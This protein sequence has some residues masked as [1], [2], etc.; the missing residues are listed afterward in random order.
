MPT[1]GSD[2]RH[3]QPGWP[4]D[5]PSASAPSAARHTNT[6]ASRP[7]PQ[8]IAL[9]RWKLG[10]EASR[11]ERRPV[12]RGAVAVLEEPATLPQTEPETRTQP[13]SV[14]AGRTILVVEDDPRVAGVIQESLALDGDAGW[15]VQTASGGLRAL[16]LAGSTPPDVVL[17]DVRLPDL[18]G[19]E[20][21]RRLRAGPQTRAARILFL[22][23]GTSLDLYRQGIEDGVL[24][25]KPFDVRDLVGIVRALLAD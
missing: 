21:Y 18:D 10:A 16:D 15:V 25:R 23:A 7:R 9:P 20:V 3:L 19:A 14:E 17:L 13:R 6:R 24:L 1:S 12:A 2:S 8:L 22:T 5:M 11:G 4:H